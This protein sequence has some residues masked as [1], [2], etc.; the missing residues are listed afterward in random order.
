MD[1]SMEGAWSKTTLT[2]ALDPRLRVRSGSRSR[3]VCET[4]TASAFDS[5]STLMLRAGRPFERAT[6][7]AST[8]VSRTVPRVPSGTEPSA[9]GIG[10]FATCAAEVAELPTWMASSLSEV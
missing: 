5:F 4:S 2:D 8:E 6:V 7:V 9:A 10:H 3:M 1:F